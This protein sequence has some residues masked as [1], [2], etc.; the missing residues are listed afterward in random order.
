[1]LSAGRWS[2][3]GGPIFTAIRSTPT[4][5]RYPRPRT[6]GSCSPE[7]GPGSLRVSNVLPQ[8]RTTWLFD[9]LAAGGSLDV[10]LRLL[11]HHLDLD[12]GRRMTVDTPF[13]YL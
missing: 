7:A 6:R 11:G 4:K 8:R 5:H 2:D 13:S 1:V 12:T 10:G 9:L 3:H